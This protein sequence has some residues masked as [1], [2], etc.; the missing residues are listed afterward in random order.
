MATTFVLAA[1]AIFAAGI[2]A[3]AAV[4]VRW[5]IRREA[6]DGSVSRRLPGAVVPGVHGSG[7]PYGRLP[8]G[9]RGTLAAHEGLAVPT[10]W[11]SITGNPLASSAASGPG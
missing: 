5:G 7:A 3:A 1:L 10:G 6:Q 4:I 2:L 8:P 11:A 9:A